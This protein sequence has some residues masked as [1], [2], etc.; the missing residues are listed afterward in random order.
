MGRQGIPHGW[1]RIHEG[2]LSWDNASIWDMV[3][4]YSSSGYHRGVS[5]HS[6]EVRGDGDIAKL[7]LMHHENASV[8]TSFLEGFPF[9]LGFHT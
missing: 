4:V 1:R 8:R 3:L 2:P 6:Q 7:Y 5:F 9:E